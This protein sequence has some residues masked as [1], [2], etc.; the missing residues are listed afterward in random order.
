M[1][2]GNRLLLAESEL[3]ENRI[4]AAGK[5]VPA[6]PALVSDIIADN[7]SLAAHVAKLKT[8]AGTPSVS[9]EKPATSATENKSTLTEKVIAAKGAK[10]LAS[11]P[12]HRDPLD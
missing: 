12:A 8:L 7:A 1:E 11:L 9:T 2:C 4:R 3:Y 10:D 5:E 6:R